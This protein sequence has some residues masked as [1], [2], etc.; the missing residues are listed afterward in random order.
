MIKNNKAINDPIRTHSCGEI[1]ESNLEQTVSLCGWVS[2]RRVFSGLIFILLR[3]RTGIIQVVVQPDNKEVF[4]QAE[5][6]RNEYVVQ[7]NGT[8]SKRPGGMSNKEMNTGNVEVLASE[9]IILNKSQALPVSLELMETA[10][11]D[12]RLKYRYLDLRRPSVYKKFEIR[13][14][15]LHIIRNFFN[16]LKFIEVE[17]PILTKATPEGAR[18]YIVPSRIQKGS[19]YALPQSPQLFK[20]LLMMSGFEKYYQ[21]ARCFRDE[22]LRANRQ[23]EFTQLD[24]E[25][26]FINEEDIYSLI[27]KLICE[28]FNSILGVKLTAPFNRMSYKH[29]LENYGTD[30]PDLRYDL[31]L[32]NISEIVKDSEF[33]VF[34]RI[35]V[36]SDYRVLAICVP[37]GCELSRK[38]IDGY[39]DYLVKKKA[40]G[41][42][43]IK[44]I[45]I[46]NKEIKSP[47]LK[48]LSEGEIASILETV[49]AKSGDL[50]FISGGINSHITKLMGN[51]RQKLATDLDFITDSWEIL[52]IY[53]WPLF[54]RNIEDHKIEPLHHPFTSPQIS[55]RELIKK[56]PTGIKARAYD[57]VINGFEVGGGSIRIHDY[58]FQKFIF[59]MIG[60]SEDDINEKFG[61]FIEALKYG[62]P[63]HG[64]I[65]FGIDR[66]A[67][68]FT[69]SK[70]IRDVITFPKTQSA[71]CLLTDAPSKVEK[72]RLDELGIIEKV[73]S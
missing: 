40:N 22:D 31:K 16:N 49:D 9:I 66:L 33:N 60:L 68:L 56:D 12:T 48:F 50:I 52:W 5:K 26:S 44:V 62:C 43:Y 64:G 14:K 53:D 28:L 63:P 17:T 59:E 54:E 23:P 2:Q 6:I 24:I 30:K 4:A 38:K 32:K 71:T 27:E 7:I 72:E 25:M 47:I 73:H 61:F 21:I 58:D 29:A 55:D 69:D 13:S 42:T 18:D 34:N 70:S 15:M 20:Q 39:I 1:T 35:K 67:M 19:Y 46:D 51:L 41:L 11:E 36:E 8:V 3:D 57:M 65:A 37:G 10:K 45:N